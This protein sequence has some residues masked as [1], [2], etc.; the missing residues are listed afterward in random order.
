MSMDGSP[1][2]YAGLLQIQEAL[3]QIQ[4]SLEKLEKGGSGKPNLQDAPRASQDHRELARRAKRGA[5][6]DQQDA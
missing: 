6:S 1:F 5:C 4:T 3:S 2:G